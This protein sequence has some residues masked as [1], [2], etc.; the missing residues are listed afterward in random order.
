MAFLRN[1]ISSTLVTPLLP[2]ESTGLTTIGNTNLSISSPP[3]GKAYFKEI[4]L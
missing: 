3:Q 1:E 2:A 4:E